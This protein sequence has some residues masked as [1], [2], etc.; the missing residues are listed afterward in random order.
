MCDFEPGD[1]PEQAGCDQADTNL[2]TFPVNGIDFTFAFTGSQVDGTTATLQAQGAQNILD[3]IRDQGFGPEEVAR[4][5]LEG[6]TAQIRL[7][8]APAGATIGVATLGE[9]VLIEIVVTA[10]RG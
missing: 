1:C 2:F 3:A 5:Q 9:G 4:V 7:L 6:G 10:A 8:N